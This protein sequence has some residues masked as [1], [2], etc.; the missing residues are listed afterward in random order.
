MVSDKAL[1]CPKCGCPVG[2]RTASSPK[3]IINNGVSR[4][5]DTNK[6]L[7]GV[8]GVLS[9]ILLALGVFLLLSHNGDEKDMAQDTPSVS[10][11]TSDNVL[12][13][14]KSADGVKEE[15]IENGDIEGNED[16]G[17]F[18]DKEITVTNGCTIKMIAVYGGSFL[19]GGT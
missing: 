3:R 17:L 5:I 11:T 8:I 7:Y 18:E 12:D 16:N 2:Q 9:S 13:K 10:A 14:A 4:R 15:R 6:G 1:K 19:M